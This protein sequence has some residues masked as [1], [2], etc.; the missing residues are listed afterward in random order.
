MLIHLNE[1]DPFD[2]M[3]EANYFHPLGEWFCPI[4]GDRMRIR[5]DENIEIWELHFS[6]V[7][8]LNKFDF[9]NW[10]QFLLYGITHMGFAQF[11]E[12]QRPPE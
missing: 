12:D 5:N 2:Q 4:W 8:K 7:H 1:L 10:Y 11:T 3:I 9:D 6:E